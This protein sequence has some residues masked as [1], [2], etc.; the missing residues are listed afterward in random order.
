[1]TATAPRARR[2]RFAVS[3]GTFETVFGFVY[4]ALTV[5]ASLVAANLPLAVMLLLVPNPLASWPLFLVLTL[6]LAPSLVGA[7]AAFRAMGED[8]PT[9]PVQAL[10]RG[11]RA[12]FARAGLLG[13]AT[14]AIVGVTMADLTVFAGTIWAPL[15][16]PTLLVLALTSVAVALLTLAGFALYPQVSARAIVKASVYLAVRRWYF[17]VMA[18]ALVGLTLAAVL[19]QPVLGAALVPSVLLFAVWSNAHFSF[20]RLVEAA[21]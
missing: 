14:A 7:F 16:G 15:L 19:V 2:A 1:M 17:S 12:G 21:R 8:A 6:T 9:R 5:N 3:Q 13:A 10:W 4:T 18:L 20:T 11:Y